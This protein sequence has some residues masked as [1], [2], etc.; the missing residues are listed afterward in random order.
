M[1]LAVNELMTFGNVLSEDRQSLVEFVGTT[2]AG[3]LK[4]SSDFYLVIGSKV[5]KFSSALRQLGSDKFNVGTQV[6]Q[7]NKKTSLILNISDSIDTY[8]ITKIEPAFD[9]QRI[10]VS[11]TKGV[12]Y[13]FQQFPN[14][15][16]NYKSLFL[17]IGE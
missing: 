9:G 6:H 16:N 7:T 17:D 12:I 13:Y 8:S 14:I 1:E 10:E 3:N 4:D 11:Q 2:L 15:G 5:V